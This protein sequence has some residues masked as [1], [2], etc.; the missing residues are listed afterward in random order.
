MRYTLQLPSGL[1]A[2]CLL[3][4]TSTIKAHTWVEEIRLIA[5]NGTYVGAPGYSR[6]FG[7]RLPGIDPDAANVYEL[8]PDGRPS[9]NAIL[10]TDLMCKQTQITPVQTPG[11]PRLAA[12]PQ[13]QVA[14]RYRENGHVTLF[15]TDHG[16]PAGRGTVYLYGTKKPRANDTY[17]GIHRVWNTAGTGGDRRGKLIATR[18][19]D[20]GT[21]F[22][23]NNNATSAA[24]MAAIG[25]DKNSGGDVFCQTDFQVPQEAGTKGTYSLYWVWEW[26]TLYASGALLKNQSYTSCMDID[27]I[28]QQIPAA[29]KFV[30]AQISG[31]S[32]NSV[33]IATQLSNQ[34]LV[35]PTAPPQ[36]A[37]DNP[38]PTSS[39]S[40]S[41]PV[42]SSVPAA[43]SSAPKSGANPAPAGFITV[44]VTTHEVSTAFVTITQEGSATSSIP[45]VSPSSSI[46]APVPST[47]SI[48]TTTTSTITKTVVAPKS[49]SSSSLSSVVTVP[50]VLSQPPTVTGFLPASTGVANTTS[51]PARLR[52]R[53]VRL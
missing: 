24:R 36:I 32:A 43:T 50:L 51:R 33:A 38:G 10:T 19:F 21:C 34:F 6:G 40:P 35:N 28:P 11:Y 29:G 12:A 1:A 44:T 3:A 45:P 26:P 20:D 5:S 14:L 8:P 4:I 7:P 52:A 31:T 41:F 22:Q 49:S 30:A 53:R 46:V 13:D 9:G 18:P 15:L 39:L 16:K 17:L 48:Q 25:Y 37:T 42:Q 27:M 23:V 47:S 2:I